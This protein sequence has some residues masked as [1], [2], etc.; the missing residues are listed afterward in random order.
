MADRRCPTALH[1]PQRIQWPSEYLRTELS[2]YPILSGTP[3]CFLAYVLSQGGNLGRAWETAKPDDNV[4]LP[5]L[6]LSPV[7]VRRTGPRRARW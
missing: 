1:A 7:F 3:L 4:P 6:P 5:S 2:T